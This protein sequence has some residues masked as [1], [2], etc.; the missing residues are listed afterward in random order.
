MNRNTRA[1]AIGILIASALLLNSCSDIREANNIQPDITSIPAIKPITVIA[2]STA[3]PEP[4]IV[5]REP[6]KSRS[7]MRIKTDVDRNVT[8]PAFYQPVDIEGVNYCVYAYTSTDGSTKFRVY[9]EV[10]ELEDENVMNTLKGFFDARISIN[11]KGVYVVETRKEDDPI[12]EVDETPAVMKTCPVPTRNN[13]RTY[14]KN[15]EKSATKYANDVANAEKKGEP[16]PEPT[17][18]DGLPV[19]TEETVEITIPNAVKT[20]KKIE[21]LY[22]YVNVCGDNEYRRYAT[23]N[24]NESG[25]YLSDEEGNISDGALMVNCELDFV[26]ENFRSGKKQERPSD[27]MYRLPVMIRL[28]DGN[29]ATV[30]TVYT[31]VFEE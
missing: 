17:P 27:N 11:G 6:V 22:Y 2:E 24:G 4:E 28:S 20:Y 15:A 31:R 13:K 19:M 21:N 23:P 7:P 12:S 25:F 3:T 1:G 5:I 18:W 14:I 16:K 29:T 9:A 8:V 26:K 30:Y 10:D